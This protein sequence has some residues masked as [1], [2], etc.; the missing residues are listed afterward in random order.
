MVIANVFPKLQTVKDLVRP[1]SKKRCFR[2]PFDSQH[3]K[4][5]QTLVKSAW[6]HFYHIFSSYWWKLI[7]KTSLL[8]IGEILGVFFNTLTNDDKYLLQ[9][10]EDLLLPI[11]V[12]LCKKQKTF[13]DF[14]FHFGNIHPIL[15]I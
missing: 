5:L 15:N 14:L 7:G 13:P 1:L 3:V 11:Q 8:V 12:Q 4:E 9:S 10:C 2:T 6:E